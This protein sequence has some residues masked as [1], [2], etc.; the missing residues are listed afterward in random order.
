MTRAIGL[1][2]AA[3]LIVVG[4]F[5][6]GCQAASA[7]VIGDFNVQVDG[8]D[9][10]V[11]GFDVYEDLPSPDLVSI[12]I[13]GGF[14]PSGSY[15][16]AAGYQY[17]WLQTVNSTVPIYD[18]QL[19]GRTYM[20]RMRL[21]PP[22]GQ[23]VADGSPFYNFYRGPNPEPPLHALGFT[24]NPTRYPD[25]LAGV[26]FDGV[27]SLTL[28]AA[29]TPPEASEPSIVR[30]IYALSTFLWGFT[31]DLDGNVTLKDIRQVAPEST[32]LV[33]AFANDPDSRTF[34][35]SWRLLSGLPGGG[36]ETPAVPEPSSLAMGL[37]AVFIAGCGLLKT[38]RA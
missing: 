30:D 25:D 9:L 4:L 22:T 8:Q 38:R 2:K 1:W 23:T 31:V 12:L 28:V 15:A 10:G 7:G 20:D 18:W 33:E 19:P 17:L 26:G 11:V 27:W 24:D 37:A 3:P 6:V 35:D 29:Q 14:D 5:A 13:R 36:G 32:D 21:D 34:G 16:L